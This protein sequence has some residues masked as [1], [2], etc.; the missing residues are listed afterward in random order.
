[1]M[2]RLLRFRH[3]LLRKLRTTL[4]P[5][6]NPISRWSFAFPYSTT[7]DWLTTNVLANSIISFAYTQVNMAWKRLSVDAPSHDVSLSVFL[8]H[9]PSNTDIPH[10]GPWMENHV[11]FI[12]FIY[13]VR[14]WHGEERNAMTSRHDVTPMM[15]RL[16]RNVTHLWW[17]TFRWH[18]M[19]EQKPLIGKSRFFNLVTFTFD[20]WPWPSNSAEILS[21]SLCLPIFVSI[22]Q[23]VQPRERWITDRHTHRQTDTPGRFCALDRWRGREICPKCVC[24]YFVFSD[25]T[26][27]WLEDRLLLPV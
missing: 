27:G 16:R 25:L 1:M 2:R 4:I 19:T 24:Y 21:R 17:C 22:C 10:I 14:S 26:I 8:P 15:S 3:R 9:K 18:C 7:A 11:L 23:T 13:S 6:W 5:T 20:L 12:A